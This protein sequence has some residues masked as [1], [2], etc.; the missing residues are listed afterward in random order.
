MRQRTASVSNG[1]LNRRFRLTH[2]W[3]VVLAIA[4]AALWI[5]AS[6]AQELRF[7]NG[8]K[9]QT[10]DLGGQ[11]AALQKQNQSYR[12]DIAASSTGAAGDEEARQNGYAKPDERQ[13]VVGQ[14]PSPA[15][16]RAAAG[17]GSAHQAATP[18]PF[19]RFW[20]WLSGG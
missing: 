16:V 7:T 6:F 9:H 1:R 5:L 20:S 4:L 13:F 11:N 8:L 19:Q 10:R 12:E 14:P 2:E 15:P 17:T 18:N 3:V